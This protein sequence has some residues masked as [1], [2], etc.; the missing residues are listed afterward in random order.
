MTGSQALAALRRALVPALLAATAALALVLAL[1]LTRAPEHQARVGIVVTP[2]AGGD[3]ADPDFGAVVSSVMPALP[4]VAVSSPVVDRLEGRVPGIDATTLAE[5]VS[6][7]LVPASGVARVTATGDSPETA[8]AVLDAVVDEIVERDLV[9][10]VG[11]FTVLGDVGAE[12]TPVRPDPLLAGGLGLL[13]AAV[14]GLLAVAAVQVLRPRLLTVADVERVVGSVASPDVAVVT[15]GRGER[16][17]DLLAARLAL[18]APGARRVHGFPAGGGG[19]DAAAGHDDLVQAL[20]ERLARRAGDP[21]VPTWTAPEDPGRSAANGR[22]ATEAR[23]RV[24][25]ATS[26]EPAVVTV[27]LRR[28]TPEQLTAAL[29]TALAAGHPI[30]AVVAR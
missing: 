23:H 24:R 30:G 12:T 29:L 16:G 27:H 5:S 20:A 11:T 28:T 25:E 15:V 13:A 21:S 19:R 18:A 10:P 2:A 17:L 8:T 1:L 26:G 7:E 14:V 4:E 6:V 3:Q 22:T 9:A